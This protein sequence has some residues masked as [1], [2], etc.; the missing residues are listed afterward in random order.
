MAFARE[1]DRRL[2]LGGCAAAL[3]AG[4]IRP[5]RAAYPERLITVVVPFPPGGPNDII[6]RIVAQKIAEGLGAQTI[7]ENRPGA[8]GATAVASVARGEPDGY[9][10]VLP[11]GV[12]FVTQP[13]LQPTP[14]FDVRALK[15]V[16]NVTSGPSVI[17]VRRDLP[18]KTLKEFL[19][20][21]K[22][23]PGSLTYAS[24]GVGTTL[25]LGGELFKATA[26]VDLVHVPYKGTSEVVLDLV[27][28]RVDMSIISPLVARK[29]VDDGRVTALATTG[30]ER[31]KGWDETPTAIEAGLAGYELD[32]WYPLLVPARTPDEIV[33]RLNEAVAKGVRAPDAA[34]RLAELGF[35]PIGSSVADGEALQAAETQKWGRL[36]R[37]AGLKAG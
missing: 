22:A 1:I 4:L 27:G 21:A 15:V 11:S 2:L 12:G 34:N 37:E 30:K 31:M 3:S 29:L 36:I 8:G 28:G 23:K 16:S 9:V 25:H 7:V 10:A 35:T 6:G 13:L 19:D 26:G 5:A 32:G 24:S 14:P 33:A 17:A 20:L 18:V